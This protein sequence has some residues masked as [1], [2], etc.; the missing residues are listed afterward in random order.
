MRT[1]WGMNDQ[2]MTIDLGATY[3]CHYNQPVVGAKRLLGKP[4]GEDAQYEG[5]SGK[6]GE[7]DYG[8]KNLRSTAEGEPWCCF[9]ANTLGRHKRF[10]TKGHVSARYL[11]QRWGP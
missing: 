5:D 6:H 1:P 11:I 7:D 4:P 3:Q 9:G 8:R 2:S 10:C